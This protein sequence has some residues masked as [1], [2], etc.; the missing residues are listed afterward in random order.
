MLSEF[1]QAIIAHLDGVSAPIYQADCVPDG[2]PCPY[3]TL[4]ATV[5]GTLTLTVWHPTNAGRIALAEE[6]STLLPARGT[7][8]PLGT[9]AAILTG[10]SSTFLREAPL[11]GL[12]MVWK[13]QLYPA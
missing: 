3:I 10:G 7:Y 12:R 1:I 6:L 9:G 4:A 13:L 2:A 5:P 8:F 11:L